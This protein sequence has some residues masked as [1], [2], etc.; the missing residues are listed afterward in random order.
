M[1][2]VY[3]H[4]KRQNRAKALRTSQQKERQHKLRHS[5]RT[6]EMDEAYRKRVGQFIKQLIQEPEVLE[7]QLGQANCLGY[8]DEAQGKRPMNSISKFKTLIRST[9]DSRPSTQLTKFRKSFTIS[10][11]EAVPSTATH[12]RSTAAL[13]ES[14]F[15]K[16]VRGTST[17]WCL[18]GNVQA[19]QME[20]KS[21]SQKAF[22]FRAN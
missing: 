12:N 11:D 4:D 9:S 16:M 13:V 6:L 20:K 3:E 21:G 17:Q 18:P 7:D 1:F 10:Y 5:Q 15:N 22:R 14:T 2:N 19:P 8:A